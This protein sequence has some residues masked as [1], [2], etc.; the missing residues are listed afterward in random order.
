M[1]RRY[2]PCDFDPPATRLGCFG[3]LPSISVRK[4]QVF[5]RPPLVCRAKVLVLLLSASLAEL[6]GMGP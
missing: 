1:D 6:V 4:S 5:S 2:Y 3:P